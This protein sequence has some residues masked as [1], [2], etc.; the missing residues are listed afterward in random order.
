MGL[1]EI[2]EQYKLLE[3]ILTG[4]FGVGLV[5]F[6]LF[7]SPIEKIKTWGRE[8]L[9]KKKRSEIKLI[10]E[11]TKEMRNQIDQIGLVIDDHLDKQ[12]V[13]HE[14]MTSKIDNLTDEVDKIKT[15]IMKLKNSDQEQLRQLMDKIYDKRI[16]EKRISYHE[17]ERYQSLYENYESEGGNGKYKSRWEEVKTWEKIK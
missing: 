3:Y 4:L 5:I 6:I 11:A 13:Y 12:K 15:D 9:R 1:T 14:E 7:S 2:F 16:N 8:R 10:Q 17:F